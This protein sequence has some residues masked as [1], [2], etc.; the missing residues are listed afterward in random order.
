[1]SIGFTKIPNNILMHKD[2]DAMSKIIFGALSFYDRGRGCWASRE[3]LSKMIGCSLYQLRKAL[4][5]LED[6]GFILINRRHRCLTDKITVV[7]PVDDRDEPISSTDN[8]VGKKKKVK[9]LELDIDTDVD[10]I[11]ETTTA[12]DN[13]AEMPETPVEPTTTPI[14]D[15]ILKEPTDRVRAT[16]RGHMRQS[17]YNQYF[18][19]ISVIAEDESSITL[20][21]DAGQVV[22]DFIQNV[23]VDTLQ[24]LLGKSV[25]V[26]AEVATLQ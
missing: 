6:K 17:T 12:S 26:M 23:F 20:I 18:K 5:E 9:E 13:D 8:V 1:M 14:P 22:A 3:T 21:T 11:A 2:L 16:L 24:K 15:T 19:D 4:V 10:N 25:C 7:K